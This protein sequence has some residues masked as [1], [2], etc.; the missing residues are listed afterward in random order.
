MHRRARFIPIV[1]V[2]VVLALGIWWWTNRVSATD[3]PLTA[4][5]TIEATEIT[6]A[7]ELAGRVVEVLVSEGESVTAGQELIRLDGELL[8]TQLK[9]AGAALAAAQAQHAAAQANYDLLQAGA[10]S[11]QIAAAEQAVRAAEAAVSGAQAQLAQLQAGARGADIAAAEAA[12]AAA[13]A[14]LKVAQDTYDR[15]LQ[16]VTIGAQEICPGLGTREEQARAALNAA[17]E[18][19]DAANKRLDQLK[20]GAT[21]NELDAARA[22]V[23]TAQAQQAMAQAQLDLLKAGARSE[24]LAAAQAQVEAAQA[25]IEAASASREVLTVQIGKLTLTAPIDGVVLKRAIEP[26][27][28]TLPGATLLTLGNTSDLRITVYVPENRYGEIRLGQS[29]QVGV[30]SFPGETFIA[31]VTHIADQAEFTPRNV[32]TAEG[33]A[34]TVFAVRLTVTN[35]DGKLKPGMPADVK[36]DNE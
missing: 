20:A 7:P 10:H 2:S 33:R 23:E 11:D 15:T 19:Q 26:G 6:I 5:G 24:Q 28:V 3:G 16:C 17:Q 29:A 18:A 27:E 9:Q 31:A 12:V 1:A 25:Q 22:R 21:K 34:T 30:D 36:F 14:Q 13:A 35:S 32:Q 8:Q 4:S